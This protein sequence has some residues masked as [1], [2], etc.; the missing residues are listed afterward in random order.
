M[1]CVDG[2]GRRVAVARTGDAVASHIARTEGF[3]VFDCAGETVARVADLPMPAV[4]V[5][6][7]LAF[8][9]DAGVRIVI[10]GNTGRGLC[11][12][13]EA[14]GIE[15]VRGVGGDVD[16]A[17]RAWKAGAIQPADLACT[18]HENCT[19]CGNCG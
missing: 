18:E 15:V 4:S 17:A 16:D 13:F 9:Q 7:L 6:F 2:P 12:I 3:A 10:V 5:G 1:K 19:G 8:L 11:A 14:N